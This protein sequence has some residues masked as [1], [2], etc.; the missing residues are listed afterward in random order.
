MKRTA[1]AQW[2]GAGIDGT[3][4]LTTRSGAFQEQP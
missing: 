1:T 4:S 2:K 3:G